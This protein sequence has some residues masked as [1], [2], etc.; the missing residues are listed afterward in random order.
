MGAADTIAERIRRNGPVSFAEVQEAALFDAEDGFFTAGGGAGRAGGDFVTSPEVGS[1]FGA[2][3][4]RAVDDWWARL[5]EPDPFVVVDAGAA[6]GRL[7]AD[8]LR[9]A[10]RCA[11][12]LR[13]VLVERSATM[14]AAQRELLTLEPPDE[15]LGPVVHGA[16]PDGPPEPVA[17]LGPI[18][19][20]LDDLPRV[21]FT[22]CVIANELLDNLPVRIV[23][24]RSEGW[25]EVRVGLDGTQLVEVV[26]AAPPDVAGVADEVAAGV[27]VPVG[28]RLPVPM[29]TVEWVARVAAV[30]R[31][32]ALAVIDYISPAADLV[33]RGQQHWLRT[34]R[35]HARA[36]S[37][38]D[39]LGASD[40]TCEVPLEH[41][42][43]I[44]RRSGFDPAIVTSQAEWLRQLGIDEL[45]D[46]GRAAWDGG[47]S[48]GDLAA[49]AG[50]STVTEA[51]ALLDPAGLG[52]HQ[53]ILFERGLG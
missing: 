37:A 3:V 35:G 48:R 16:D 31:R 29:T 45:V 8:I 46:R 43:A 17:G 13:Y 23:E 1:L 34:Y 11:P 52:A 49:L 10:P 9:A 20:S 27:E 42:L 5:G 18:L 36:G 30:L 40:I 15:A 32:G 26:V 28:A 4:A 19:T 50:R 6:R 51:A 33:D 7:A 22:G 12:A 44:A 41:V 21:G 39:D 53:V 24:R 2:L 38:L 25:D 14:R 47:A